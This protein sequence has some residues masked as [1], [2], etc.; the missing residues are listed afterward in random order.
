MNA[1][2]QPGLLEG[3]DQQLARLFAGSS[4]EE[5]SLDDAHDMS[6][7]ILTICTGNVCRSPLAEALLRDRLRTFAH[8]VT[9]RQDYLVVESLGINALVGDPADSQVRQLARELGINLETHIAR[10]FE[11]EDATNFNL[12]LTATREQREIVSRLAPLAA[13]RTFT[14]IEFARLLTAMAESGELTVPQRPVQRAR[15]LSRHLDRLVSDVD[16]VRGALRDTPS[17]SDDID[18]PY[19]RDFEVHRAVA[20]NISAAVSTIS[21][22]ITRSVDP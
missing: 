20:N 21:E 1:E 13:T 16:A 14:L 7:R 9:K 3:L 10:Q 22:M 17:Q 4:A 5:H 18:D 2:S 19:R 12:I 6:F 8:Q 15:R 11:P